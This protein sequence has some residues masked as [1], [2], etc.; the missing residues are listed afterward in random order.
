MKPIGPDQFLTLRRLPIL[1]ELGF[2]NLT[3]FLLS[4]SPVL[5]KLVKLVF[6][7]ISALKNYRG[8]ISFNIRNAL[9]VAASGFILGFLISLSRLT[10]QLP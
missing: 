6:R 3:I 9:I 1:I 8:H 10:T 5:Q 4:E 2:W 7:W